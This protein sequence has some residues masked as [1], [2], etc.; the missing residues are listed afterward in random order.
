MIEGARFEVPDLVGVVEETV[1]YQLALRR[2]EPDQV[3]LL[4]RREFEIQIK[5]HAISP[6]KRKPES[7]S[8]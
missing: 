7:Q 8:C 6:D 3:H 5:S 4:A 2:R 1:A